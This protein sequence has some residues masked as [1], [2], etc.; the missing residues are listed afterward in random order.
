MFFNTDDRVRKLEE[1]LEKEASDCR[2]MANM[3]STE[4]AKAYSLKMQLED[5]QKRVRDLEA[6]KLVILQ[7]ISGIGPTLIAALGKESGTK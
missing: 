1:K 2:R 6:E 5:S 7:A 4:S 3:Y